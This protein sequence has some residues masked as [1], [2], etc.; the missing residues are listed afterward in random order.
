MTDFSM[1]SLLLCL[2]AASA[3]TAGCGGL[4]GSGT[5][6]GG[7]DSTTTQTSMAQTTTTTTTSV[8]APTALLS[9]QRV[10]GGVRISHDGGESMKANN[11][12]IVI[13]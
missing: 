1:R 4:P 5:A 6:D 2:V 9:I 8:G 12:T 7:G 3:L 13:R 10:D 11:L